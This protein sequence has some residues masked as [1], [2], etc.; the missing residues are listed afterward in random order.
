MKVDYCDPNIVYF[1]A[2]SAM[3]SN[4]SG[5]SMYKVIALGLLIDVRSGEILD[6]DINMVTPLSVQFIREQ[7]LGMNIRTDWNLILNRFD[8]L[9]IPAQKA[10]ITALKAVAE[11]Y[12]K[13]E[14]KPTKNS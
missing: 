13:Y 9:Q 5:G 12:Q 10:V 7:L 1:S 6:A 8:R 2:N 11:R 3:P 14:K 4:T